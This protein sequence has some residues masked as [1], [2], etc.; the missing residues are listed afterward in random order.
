MKNKKVICTLLTAAMCASLLAGCGKQDNGPSS[1]GGNSQNP[2]PGSDNVENST[3]QPSGDEQGSGEESGGADEAQGWSLP[4]TLADPNVRVAGYWAP[5][6]TEQAA[7]DA[8]EQKYGGKV[9]WEAVGWNKAAPA[10]QEG[11]ATGTYYDLAFTEGFKRF[12]VDAVNELY[13]P[14]DDYLDYS[15]CDQNSA[16]LF[17]YQGE[18]YVFTNKAIVS[19]YLV[20][21]NK[22]IF[23]EEAVETPLEL[24]RKG[25]WTYDKFLDYLEYFTRDTDGDGEIDQWGLGPGSRVDRALYGFANDGL[26]VY[27]LADGKLAVGIDSPECM[28]WFDFLN[29]YGTIDTKCPGDGDWLEQRLCVIYIAAGPSADLNKSTDEFDFVTMPTYDGRQATTPVWDN[30]YALATGAP[31]PEGASV[32]ATMI[33]QIALENYESN[34]LAKYDNDPEKVARYNSAMEKTIPQA[35]TYEGVDAMTSN[36]DATGGKPAQTV[37]E[38]HKSRLE[39]EVAA[40]NEKLGQ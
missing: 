3:D 26:Q 9:T 12:P 7:I 18:H 28:Q 38:E 35:R 1:S 10:I 21:Y 5:N 40:Y 25:E 39:A 32:L 14:I 11:M 34:L 37:V 4:D 17:L 20:M 31:N 16:D 2:A 33:C 27:E 23:D 29:R 24:F 8:F 6:E 13:Q 15:V 36:R 19:P 22:S 30:G